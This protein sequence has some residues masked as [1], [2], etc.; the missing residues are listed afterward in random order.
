MYGQM[1]LGFFPSSKRMADA[2]QQH[3][4]GLSYLEIHCTTFFYS[5]D[6]NNTFLMI[7]IKITSDSFKN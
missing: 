2:A 5:P 1:R 4:I 6:G 3:G 7:K